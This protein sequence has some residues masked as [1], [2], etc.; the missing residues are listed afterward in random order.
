MQRQNLLEIRHDQ[1]AAASMGMPPGIPAAVPLVA[2]THGGSFFVVQNREGQSAGN[3]TPLYL[4]GC[5]Y[6][7]DLEGRLP[8]ALRKDVC[9]FDLSSIVGDVDSCSF[10]SDGHNESLKQTKHQFRS[11]LMSRTCWTLSPVHR[12][13]VYLCLYLVV[14]LSGL[15]IR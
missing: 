3:P 6:V 5:A 2:G 1:A 12:C 9:G 11:M 13:F 15:V 7:D 10:G 14:W 4:D 8:S